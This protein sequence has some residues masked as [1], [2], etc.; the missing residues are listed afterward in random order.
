[1][2]K[3]FSQKIGLINLIKFFQRKFAVTSVIKIYT[4]MWESSVHLDY[5]HLYIPLASK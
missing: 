3:F 5:D 4:E 1:M 2:F